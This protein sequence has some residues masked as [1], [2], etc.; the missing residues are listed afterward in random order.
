MFDYPYLFTSLVLFIVSMTGYWFL[1]KH[2]RTLLISGLFSAPCS[3]TTFYFVPDYWHPVRLFDFTLGIEDM[4]FSFSTGMMAW[5]II[6]IRHRK[7]VSET[8]CFRVLWRYCKVLLLG[9]AMILLARQIPTTVMNQALIGIIIIG[10]ILSWNRWHVLP[11]AILTGVMF[12]IFYT[13][14]LAII[15]FIFPGFS[16][17]WNHPNLFGFSMLNIPIEECL[18]AFIFGT[19]W[20]IAM[21]FVLNTKFSVPKDI[22]QA[23][24]I[25]QGL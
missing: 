9:L 18:W 7:I 22:R 12:A 2:R 20:V 15:F 3:L 17:Q 19:C 21:V 24:P 13:L 16:A 6:T 25:D 11:S 10:V 4:L 23:M 14:F 5:S 1:S 8:T